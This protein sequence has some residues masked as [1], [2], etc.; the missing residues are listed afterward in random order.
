LEITFNKTQ[1]N[2]GII[3]ISVNRTDFQSN[4]D[5]KIKEYSRKAE[6]KGFRKGKVP[7]G[8]IKKMYGSAL[9][10]DE[11][12]KL[13]SDKLNGYLKENDT[14]F[15][16]EPLPASQDNTYDW[17]NQDE[18]EFD[19]EI[20]F[21]EPFEIILDKK[22]KIEKYFIKVDQQVLDE[23]IDNLQRQFGETENTEVSAEGDILNGEVFVKSLDLTKEISIDFRDVEKNSSQKTCWYQARRFC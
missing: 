20:G 3:K 4:V 17:D 21:A 8:M 1:P 13:V 10:I 18:F 6:I 16:G 11:I 23:T 14:Q 5:Q 19:Y 9:I 12:N 2:Q 22:K 7:V 15:L